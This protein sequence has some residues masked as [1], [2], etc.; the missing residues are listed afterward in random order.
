MPLKGAMPQFIL[1]T[2]FIPLYA[3]EHLIAEWTRGVNCLRAKPE[4]FTPHILKSGAQGSRLAD[5][6]AGAAFGLLG[7]LAA[8]KP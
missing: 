7:L 4:F 5:Q 6:I 2:G 3:A 1:G 8:Q